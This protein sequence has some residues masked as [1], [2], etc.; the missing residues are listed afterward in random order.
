MV[1]KIQKAS[2][3]IQFQEYTNLYNHA[4]PLTDVDRTALLNKVHVSDY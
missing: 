2:K 3:F 4:T 1:A